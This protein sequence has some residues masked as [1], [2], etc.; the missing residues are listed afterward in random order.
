MTSFAAT[1]FR[2]IRRLLQGARTIAPPHAGVETV[3][4]GMTAVAVTESCISEVA[5][6]GAG[7]PAA[8]AARAWSERQAGEGLNRF[9]GPLG[10]V[11]AESPRGGLAASMGMTASGL[12]AASFLSG[13]D[14]AA[15]HDLLTQAVGQHLPLMVHLACRAPAGHAPALG[16]GHETCHSVS[17]SG[18]FQLMA[19]NVQEA[20][21]LA[22]IARRTAELALIP[23]LVAM[24][25]EQTALAGQDVLLP[26]G[27]LIR[28]FLG[29]PSDIIE[30]P[31]PAQRLLFGETRRR[32]PR[33]YDLQ[34]PTLLGSLQGPESW[35][36]GAAG[37][38]PYFDTHLGDFLADA[39]R[40][41]ADQTG[42]SYDL[43][44][45]HRLDGAEI[46]LIAQGAAFETCAALA[47]YRLGHGDSTIG[48][49]GVRCLRPFPGA[50]IVEQV[51]NAR[52]VAVL[53]RVS[54]PFAGDGPL[55]AE[56]RAAFH[57]AAENALFGPAMH[58]G[59]PVVA[60]H[61]RPQ[62]VGVPF[63]LG[64]M[65]LRAT[66][67]AELCAELARP[68][69]S[70]IYLG[71][72]FVRDPSAFPKR[73]ALMDTVR[74]EYPEVADL[75][76]RSIEAGPDVRP[77]GAVTIALHRLAGGE[78]ETLAG[79]AAELIHNAMG[80]HLRSRP[81]LTW[82]RFD[83]PCVDHLT[84]SPGALLDPGD[85]VSVDIA[86]LAAPRVHHLMDLTAGLTRGGAILVLEGPVREDG[87][88]SLPANLGS[89]LAQKQVELFVIQRPAAS[90]E[91]GDESWRH[92][93]A[94]L[95][96]LLALFLIR[97]GD[98]QLTAD[99]ARAAR[100]ATLGDVPDSERESRL[101]A[102]VAAF[103]SLKQ[104]DM[105]AS[106]PDI[107]SR[108]PQDIPVPQAV[109]QLGRPDDALDSLP[110][111]WDQ[112]GVLYRTGRKDELAADPQLAVNA[113]PVLTSTFRDVTG[114]REL[115]PE[116]D[117]ETCDG[118][119]RLWTSCPD[120][121]IAPLVISA[122][123][124]IEAGINIASSRGRP[125]DALRAIAGQLARRINRIIADSDHPPM[126]AGE[127]LDEA[128][129]AV[130]EKSDFDQDRKAS[131]KEAFDNL[132]EVIGELPLAPTEI[133]FAELERKATGTGEFLTVAV[134][135]DACKSSSL[136]LAACEG[137][138][139]QA[140]EQTPE[141][142]EKARRLWDLWQQLPDTSGE[143]IERAR[144]HPKVG[145]LAAMM[146]SRHCLMAMA[147]GD[148]AEPG[149]GA[150]LALRQVLAACEYHLQPRLQDHLKQI[151]TLRNKLAD[152]IRELLA[153]A[154]PTAD[155]DALAEGLAV[156][157][158]DDVD[159]ASL[160]S[161][162]D[163]AVTVG[164][165]DGARLRRL[166]EVARGLA[167]LHWRLSH[168]PT[169]LGRARVGLTIAPGSVAAWSAAFPHN[170]FSCPV[171]VD[172]GGET[173]QLARGVLEGQL[174]QALAGIR[175]MRWARL[176][177][178]CPAEA[179][180]AA[181]ALAA[182]RY[183]DL[184]EEERR[185]CPPL[186]LV[187]DG[188]SLGGRGLSQLMCLLNS[189][190]PVRVIV[191]G[192]IGGQAD[193]GLSVDSLGSY[194]ATERFDLGL[195]A[196]LNRRAFVVQTS[197]ADGDHFVNGVLAALACDGPVLIHVHS[198]SPER[199]GFAI[200]RMH[201][202][203]RLAVRSR[204]FPLLRFDP[205]AEGVFGSCLDLSGN[206]DID[207]LWCRDEHDGVLTPVDWAATERRFAHH[208]RPLASDD[209][210]HTPVA[211]YLD[212]SP[213]ERSGKTPFV[214]VKGGDEETRLRVG[215]AL[216]ADADHRM[217]LW[218]TIQELAGVVTPFTEK[219][220]EAAEQDLSQAHADEIARLKQE[221]ETKIAELTAGFE[222]EATQRVTDR[223]LAI[224]GYT[225]DQDQDGDD[226]S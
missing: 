126:T 46:V 134:N 115:L 5:G 171:L 193:G 54:A 158:R 156:L 70:R 207:S 20:V 218:R 48:V 88:R 183:A 37:R 215:P 188:Q 149:S 67:L 145:P 154:L 117:P 112:T 123:A 106:G 24:D 186:L 136:V 33:F 225:A 85:A 64:G 8:G 7:F 16:T 116:F 107:P 206:P 9:G 147:G 111:F 30:P 92:V 17:G 55:L 83:E 200:E 103:Q 79:E 98:V 133:F 220:R 12:R 137:R 143:T 211:Q 122:K 52:V 74:R 209:P 41:F 144:N 222:A 35:A 19:A 89:Q 204:A 51:K 159:I 132:I 101:D 178:E 59:H 65:P 187:G 121:S 73:Q 90:D 219:V 162:V 27:G 100:E 42:R 197:L 63:G 14:L 138:G 164:K 26:D 60:E 109:R 165:V 141:N 131:L 166:V 180:R 196:I 182:L 190:L 185:L 40:E 176:E 44:A 10:S 216:I 119:G 198:P 50:Q 36:L 130:L 1:S 3:L 39:M 69:R 205:S 82:Q 34:H 127:L 189:D 214:A 155:L 96:G 61:Q 66:D 25:G 58:P 191:L 223:L 140:V 148:G 146:L 201:E 212:L 21:D 43:I 163:E 28:A 173:S 77:E 6:L 110:R 113:V 15:V 71:V 72:D 49:L 22:L 78:G 47:D 95:G 2:L 169:G 87:L 181:E 221:Y 175:L 151:D 80:G 202:Q 93:E 56:T 97:S 161:K 129:P 167:D 174:R 57:R 170:P 32:V 91:T 172:A 150:K 208:F 128:F 203:A 192:E 31:T 104:A 199:H 152:S 99:Q 177:L 124:L 168:G 194:P 62:L 86:V 45:T 184:T 38:T 102:F 118:D 108:K 179:A 195:L 153:D 4:D 139:L 210:I 84:H 13:T 142:L 18:L 120:G 75:S 125:A 53:E 157:G 114:A 160:S 76:L 81:A 68:R 224:A 29:D 135:P 217:R 226:A 11:D 213:S 105:P 94:I 23:G